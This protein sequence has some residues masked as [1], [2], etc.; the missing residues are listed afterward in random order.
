MSNHTER[1]GVGACSV[2]AEKNNWMFRELPNNDIGIDAHMEFINA[3]GKTNQLLALQIK[4]GKSW[5]EEKKKNN[6]IFRQIND[7]QYHYW[8]ANSLPCIMVL[9]NPE[10]E[11][12]IWQKLTKETI[13]RTK[14]GKGKGYFVEIPMNQIFLDNSSNQKLLSYTNL[15]EYIINYNFLLSQKEFM[16]ILKNGGEIKLHSTEWI[17]KSSGRGEIKL[18]VNYE[19]KITT[20]LYPYWFPYTPYD[21]VFPKLFPWANF[22]ADEEYYQ[23]SDETSWREYH[24]YYDSE[25]EEWLVVGETFEEYRNKLSPIR[26]INH[27]DEVAE[28]M[29]ILSL[30]E[31]GESFLNLNAFVSHSQIYVKARPKQIEKSEKINGKN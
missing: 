5:F 3:P 10:D 11:M 1:I 9:Y 7:R 30:N 21:E 24:C 13:K 4:S 25:D 17:N 18:I 6:I 27:M 12:C 29:L 14:E 19:N 26:S 8:I 15:P 23:Q 28:Y 16:Q 2:I 31:L 22:S 20:Y